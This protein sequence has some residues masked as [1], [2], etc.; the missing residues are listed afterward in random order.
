MEVYS[1]D[2]IS[3]NLPSESKASMSYF[4][5]EHCLR[6]FNSHLAKTMAET[7]EVQDNVHEEADQL[8]GTPIS[9]EL[10][11]SVDD[12]SSYRTRNDASQPYLANLD[13]H[14]KSSLIYVYRLRLV[15]ATRYPLTLAESRWNGASKALIEVFRDFPALLYS[16]S[17]QRHSGHDC[18]TF[19]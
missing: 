14:V 5:T 2:A 1:A 15:D 19:S 16:V 13:A 7:L 9:L 8:P 18:I 6:L 11:P 12:S 17:G 10:V 4:G 3:L